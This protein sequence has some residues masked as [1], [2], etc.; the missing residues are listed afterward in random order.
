MKEENKRK[1]I[2]RIKALKYLLPNIITSF[3]LY[4]IATLRSQLRI[5]AR[6]PAIYNDI[7]YSIA[8]LP[9]VTRNGISYSIATHLSVTRNDICYEP[10]PK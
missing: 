5:A 2:A 6:A 8:T 3:V 9:A 1:K 7:Y 4:E 10:I